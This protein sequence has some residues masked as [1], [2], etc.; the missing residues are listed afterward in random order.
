M[1]Q[2][3]DPEVLSAQ[4]RHN[5]LSLCGT[6]IE[7]AL[8]RHPESPP[9]RSLHPDT[10]AG[11]V[12]SGPSRSSGIS[13]VGVVSEGWGQRGQEGERAAGTAGMRGRSRTTGRNIGWGGVS[14]LWAGLA[15]LSR[16]SCASAGV[17]GTQLPPE[18]AKTLR[19]QKS[20]FLLLQSSRGASGLRPGPQVPTT[21]E[22]LREPCTGSGGS[23]ACPRHRLR[24]SRR[25][26]LRTEAPAANN[27][28]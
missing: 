19:R 7:L 26:S 16:C 4:G 25:G 6:A 10:S 5:L 23:P 14:A 18:P 20:S 11:S 3:G 24:W 9:L 17:A 15:S 22:T 21:P 2:T 1:R 8:R 12:D 28:G 13:R 27:N